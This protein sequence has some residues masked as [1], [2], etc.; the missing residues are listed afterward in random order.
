MV[1]NMERLRSPD[2]VL[3]GDMWF[4]LLNITLSIGEATNNPP[5]A[6][7][8]DDVHDPVYRQVVKLRMAKK[9]PVLQILGN[10]TLI[11]AGDHGDKTKI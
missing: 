8:K 3:N 6:P 9:D 11:A 2:E 10:C 4:F 5:Q 1:G 7:W